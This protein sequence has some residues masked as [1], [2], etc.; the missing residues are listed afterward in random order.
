MDSDLIVPVASAC[1]LNFVGSGNT[2]ILDGY[3]HISMIPMERSNAA[4]HLPYQVAL[5]ALESGSISHGDNFIPEWRTHSHAM[6]IATNDMGVRVPAWFMLYN[7][8]DPNEKVLWA[9]QWYDGS[10]ER[11]HA[12][13]ETN[14]GEWVL[15]A[16]PVGAAAKQYGFGTVDP[17]SLDATHVEMATVYLPPSADSDSDGLTDAFETRYWGSPTSEHNSLGDADVDGYN[18]YTEQIMGTDP[19]D[20]MSAFAMLNLAI[21]RSSA[22]A[23]ASMR[24]THVLYESRVEPGAVFSL[25]IPVVPDVAYDLEVSTQLKSGTWASTGVTITNGSGWATLA[26]TNQMDGVACYRVV[27]RLP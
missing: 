13:K 1:P 3:T 17:F 10:G 9:H 14:S 5:E 6:I 20:G 12:Y 11:I 26:A 15:A 23:G 16:Y 24:A 22:P 21:A 4:T 18:N 8:A 7:K 25:D 2:V 27:I 19:T